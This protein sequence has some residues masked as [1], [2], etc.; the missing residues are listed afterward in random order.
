VSDQDVAG[1]LA[2]V[3]TSEHGSAFSL[4]AE[5]QPDYLDVLALPPRGGTARKRRAITPWC[6]SRHAS[7]CECAGESDPSEFEMGIGFDRGTEQRYGV[8]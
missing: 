7:C 4:A 2:K 5:H 6:L 8:G 3:L 1:K